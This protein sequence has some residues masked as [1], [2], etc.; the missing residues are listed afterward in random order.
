[1]SAHQ[2]S[3]H[4]AAVKYKHAIN[5]WINMPFYEN[6]DAFRTA[7]ADLHKSLVEGLQL[8]D[9]AHIEEFLNSDEVYMDICVQWHLL[10]LAIQGMTEKRSMWLYE[11]NVQLSKMLMASKKAGWELLLLQPGGRIM[12]NSCKHRK[13]SSHRGN[14]CSD[15]S[16]HWG[17]NEEEEKNL[18]AMAL[19]EGHPHMEALLTEAQKLYSSRLPTEVGNSDA[20]QQTEDYFAMRVRNGTIHNDIVVAHKKAASA[21]GPVLR[22]IPA[23]LLP[24]NQHE[25]DKKLLDRV[26]EYHLLGLAKV[27]LK[28]EHHRELLATRERIVKAIEDWLRC[29]QSHS[30]LQSV[31]HAFRYDDYD[32]KRD[33]DKA[34]RRDLAINLLS[35]APEDV[36][37]SPEVLTVV[38]K[39]NLL[40]EHDMI[41]IYSRDTSDDGEEFLLAPFASVACFLQNVHGI[42]HM[43]VFYQQRPLV[44][45]LLRCNAR[46][47]TTLAY[48]EA[49]TIG[50]TVPL[51]RQRKTSAEMAVPA[52]DAASAANSVLHGQQVDD[53]YYPLWYNNEANPMLKATILTEPRHVKDDEDS[54]LALKQRNAGWEQIRSALIYCTM[55]HAENVQTLLTVLRESRE[56]ESEIN[57]DMSRL[58]IEGTSVADFVTSMT[59]DG[60]SYNLIRYEE[61]IRYADFPVLDLSTQP[62]G[63]PSQNMP[64][65]YLQRAHREI[66]DMLEWL[67]KH[68]VRRIITLRVPD[69]M[70][71]PHDELEIAE[72]VR[73]FRVEELDWRILDLSL[74]IFK[75]YGEP[76]SIPLICTIDS[77]KTKDGNTDDTKDD[78]TNET[79]EKKTGKT[80]DTKTDKTGGKTGKTS[81]IPKIMEDQNETKCKTSGETSVQRTYLRRLHLYTGGRRSALDHWFS[82]EGLESTKLDHVSIHVIKELTTKEQSNAT[83][84]YI[85]GKVEELKKRKASMKI[86]V[87]S[88]F[89]TVE[90]ETPRLQEIIH[91]L[92]PRLAQFIANYRQRASNI[93]DDRKRFRPAKVAIID[94]GILSMD[95]PSA[96]PVA[97][98]TRP[99]A[100]ADVH[101][102]GGKYNNNNKSSKQHLQSQGF[103]MADNLWARICD[104][105]SFV[106]ERDSLSPW[107]LASNPHGTQMAN[108]VCAIDPLCQLF[109]A[110]IADSHYGYSA[111]RAAEAVNWAIEKGVDIISMSF[112]T[113][114]DH[115]PFNEAVQ[116]AMGAGIL[117]VCSHHDEG[118]RL[119]TKVFPACLS[120]VGMHHTMLRMAGCNMYGKLQHDWDDYTVDAASKKDNQYDFCINS[121]DVSVGTIPFLAASTERVSG[122][123][124]ATAIA[125]G[126]CSLLIA[127]LR[128][129]DEMTPSAKADPTTK[130]G[131]AILH[132]H[133]NVRRA[134]ATDDRPSYAAIKNYLSTMAPSTTNPR[135]ITLDRFA[136][137]DELR[138]DTS[139]G[140]FKRF[141]DL[142]ANFK[143]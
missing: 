69:R 34:T 13:P 18:F 1:M 37:Q 53:G 64:R 90:T 47:A 102:R 78:N 21:L 128:T 116:R 29:P 107:Y 92:S 91:Q 121:Q 72:A 58:L 52:V 4:V 87:Q 14:E 115:K 39:N 142:A 44:E 123:S 60:Q 48:V 20:K 6:D 103:L 79:K 22:R 74:N 85:N 70:A 134:L 23:I 55:K 10:K 75:P 30:A 127:C 94:N 86:D 99:E 63:T 135:F 7:L 131:R 110:K 59:R 12:M 137:L 124:V 114:E 35:N 54:L 42:L 40:D 139:S 71:H 108:L 36:L 68:G 93:H 26:I 140:F 45:A 80:K 106:Y 9:D 15:S 98:P 65:S 95:P 83:L 118:A 88:Q 112:T 16:W 109:I 89:W 67:A 117:V 119:S 33:G 77:D 3:D 41:K 57:F 143:V 56:P 126:V 125:A 11:R 46:L 43:A 25:S 84:R 130:E 113:T 82:T 8:T 17:N 24:G 100:P 27:I 96:P 38:M 28:S 31:I 51:R 81:K 97:S 62:Q 132:M 104:G 19:C 111:A 50:G 76:E 49:S 138:D 5:N 129:L 61:T 73:R 2:A 133:E 120:S 66:P 122:S 136:R 101:D 32:G 141:L 105:K